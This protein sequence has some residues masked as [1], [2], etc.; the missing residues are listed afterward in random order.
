MNSELPCRFV[1]MAIL[2][3][4][5][6]AVNA[7]PM[8]VDIAPNG[9]CQHA[10]LLQRCISSRIPVEFGSGGLKIYLSVD[11]KLGRAESFT[12][13]KSDEGWTIT[14][15]DELGL[16][17]GIGRFLHRARWTDD[18]FHPE[19]AATG[20]SL[21]SPDCTFR[22]LYLCAHFYNW[23]QMASEEE[24]QEYI[25][26][27]L[28]WGY[29]TVIS[30]TPLPSVSSFDEAMFRDTCRK[31][32]RVFAFCRRLGMRTGLIIT[33]NQGLKSA[34]HEFDA[35]PPRNIRHR[36]NLGRNLCMS[37]PAAFEY[38][39]GIWR[40][41]LSQFTANSVDY[42]LA[43]PYD[44]GGC[45]CDGCA[46][47]GAKKFLDCSIALRD[48]VRDMQSE[49]KTIISTWTFDFDTDEGEYAGLY[50][51]LSGDMAWID[52][53]MVDSHE[54]F[55]GYVLKHPPIK[56]IVNFP[57]ISMWGLRPWG[58][59]GANPLPRRFQKIWDSSRRVLSGGMP[60]SE[61]KFEDLTKVQWAGYYWD[62]ERN[63]TD[64]LKEYAAYEYSADVA[65]DAVRLMELIEVNHAGYA[66]GK[67]IDMTVSRC[68]RELADSIDRR[69]PE[70][71][72]T[73]WRWRLLYLRAQLDERRYAYLS[74]HEGTSDFRYTNVSLKDDPVAQTM[75]QELCRI[76]RCVDYNGENHWT[77]PPTNGGYNDRMARHREGGE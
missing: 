56:P 1:L 18:G 27:L 17:Y 9:H 41:I 21:S 7:A 30:D 19:A 37:K 46:P 32:D 5:L 8:R 29:N 74:A 68:A 22:A 14:G 60:Y 65:E 77:H 49:A 47:W 66:C 55:P 50:A 16:Y 13:V 20:K 15:A 44:E 10:R 3:F 54:A 6:H 48:I 28:L 23:Y 39:K 62:A 4:A 45:G 61:G 53:L 57:E 52:S 24:L 69:L 71:A 36:G 40:G 58:G 35:V 12:I 25:E 63:Y 67:P 64:I 26:D 34:P 2:S 11:A 73:A 33:L 76:Y 31:L 70:R 43:W 75:L 38:V 59:F 42:V 72:K 51:R